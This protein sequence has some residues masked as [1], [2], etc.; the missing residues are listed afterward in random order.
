MTQSLAHAVR[1]FPTLLRVGMAEMV[2]YRS[3]F[4]I[5]ILTTNMPLVMMGLWTAVAAEGPVGRFG[6]RQFV[7]YYLATLIIRLLTSSWMVWELTMDIR[8]GTLAMRLLRPLHPLL[9]Y[10]AEHLAAVPLRALVTSPLLVVLWLSAGD[11]LTVTDPPRLMILFASLA[12][13]W[14]VL[15]FMMA[16]IGSLAIFV[17]SAIAVFEIWLGL[18]FILSGYLIPLELLP[19]W[20]KVTAEVLPFRYTLG[21]PV[22][23]LVGLMDTP[24]ALTGLGIQWLYVAG[25]FVTAALVWRA[26]MRRFVA[27]G[28]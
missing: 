5:W 9:A 1:A 26:G 27:F 10:A 3:E 8:Q 11:Q 16:I 14:L 13:A 21:F 28:G 6:E 19:P 18:H 22:E 25:L 7:A 24:A 2:A 4:L 20:V 23:V 12:G 15:F 17:D